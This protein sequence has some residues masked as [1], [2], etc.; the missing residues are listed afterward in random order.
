MK[1]I[2]KYNKEKLFNIYFNTKLNKFKYNKI[3]D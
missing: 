1:Y 2:N 3:I